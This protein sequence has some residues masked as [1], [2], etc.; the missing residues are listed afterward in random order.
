MPFSGIRSP[1]TEWATGFAEVLAATVFGAMLIRATRSQ[2]RGVAIV[3][4]LAYVAAINAAQVL[5][6]SRV[7]DTTD[8]L[9]A[10]A[11]LLA[12]AVGARTRRPSEPP[13]AA[14]TD[15]TPPVSPVGPL[16]EVDRGG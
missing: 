6:V 2:F 14:G 7:A 4:G 10:G 3:L 11:G 1:A 12:G 16:A 9:L 8:L 15:S 5:I 13:Q